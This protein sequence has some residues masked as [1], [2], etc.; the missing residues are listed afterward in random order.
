MK[1]VRI[2]LK[3][4]CLPLIV[5]LGWMVWYFGTSGLEVAKDIQVELDFYAFSTQ[6]KTYA[7]LAG[8]IPTT[9]Q[10]LEALV[11]HPTIPPYPKKWDQLLFNVFKDPWHRE[12][13]YRQ[14]DEKTFEL[15]SE[16]ERAGDSSDDMVHQETYHTK[17]D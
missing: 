12:Y 2:I 3:I 1:S 4:L 5:L 15:R 8:Q 16:G 7:E 10:G 9:E 6:L 13:Q 17:S 11:S 14:I